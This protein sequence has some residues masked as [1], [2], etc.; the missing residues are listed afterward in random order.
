MLVASSIFAMLDFTFLVILTH[1]T[2]NYHE[3]ELRKERNR[4][5]TPE[6]TSG[7]MNQQKKEEQRDGALLFALHPNFPTQPWYSLIKELLCK[8]ERYHGRVIC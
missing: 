3:D 6:Q 8:G 2:K 5:N 7:A 4:R 1:R